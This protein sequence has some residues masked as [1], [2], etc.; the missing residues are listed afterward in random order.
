MENMDQLTAVS[1]VL[2]AALCA[3][4]LCYWMSGG[5]K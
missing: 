4:V 2:C 1:V 3:F 5:F